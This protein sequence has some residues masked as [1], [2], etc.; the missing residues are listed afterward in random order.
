MSIPHG[1]APTGWQQL[2]DTAKQVVASVEQGSGQQL[3]WSR[4]FIA[5]ARTGEDLATLRGWLDGEGIPPGLP[6]DTE[7]RWALIQALTANGKADESVIAAELDGDR[8]ASGE[9][10]AAIA[11]SLVRPRQARPRPGAS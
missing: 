2:A 6:I 5:S 9:R 3:A 10:Q 8:T 11:R 7:V 1:G 4:A